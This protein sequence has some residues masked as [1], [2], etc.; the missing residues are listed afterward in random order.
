MRDAISDS[1]SEL[2]QFEAIRTFYKKNVLAPYYDIGFRYTHT[3]KMYNPT[4]LQAY[5]EYVRWVLCQ[6]YNVDTKS[7]CPNLTRLNAGSN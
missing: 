1:Q 7:Y 4:V 6:K 2:G 3:F 5:T